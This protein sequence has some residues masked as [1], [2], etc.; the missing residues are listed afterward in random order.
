M[1][2]KALITIKN[3]QKLGEEETSVELI[4]EGEYEYSPEKAVIKY[5]ETGEDTFSGTDAVLTVEND[6]AV[7]V[8]RGN[9]SSE[10]TFKKGIEHK[11]DYRT[12]YGNLKLVS[13][14]REMNAS[15]DENGGDVLISYL[16]YMEGAESIENS[17]KIN[18]KEI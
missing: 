12:P 3:K 7:L 1:I 11:C 14:T 13:I 8:R 15:L 2:K 18:V 6:T 17:I 9:G 16:L 10:M 5:K 4:S